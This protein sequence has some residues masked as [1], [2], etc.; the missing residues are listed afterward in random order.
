MK[1]LQKLRENSIKQTIEAIRK[2]VN[3]DSLINHTISNIGELD[4]VANLLVKRLREWFSLELPELDRSIQD[5][6]VFIRQILEKNR[7][8]LLKELKLTEN[9]SMGAKLEK[10]DHDEIVLLAKQIQQLH[11]LR[12]QHISYLEN[13]MKGYCPNMLEMCGT[14][15]AASLIEHAG[16]LKRLASFPS[17]TVQLLGA[18]KALFRHLTKKSKPPKY[19]LIINHPI[20]TNADKDR[21]GKAAR[22]LADKISMAARLDYFKGEFK[23]KELKEDL[24]RRFS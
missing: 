10:K 13:V 16:S 22:A 5:H 14:T 2:S 15:I 8:Q 3:E 17:S 7:N 9:E 12:D 19:G 6:E 20:V 23:A 18:E 1:S 11:A 4:K 24:E 21:K